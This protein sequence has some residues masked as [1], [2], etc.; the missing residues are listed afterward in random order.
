MRKST[1]RLWIHL[2]FPGFLLAALA[3]CGG[4]GGYGGGGGGN[5][6]QS[7]PP[8]GMSLPGQNL[9][10]APAPAEPFN[11]PS[12]TMTMSSGG[13][14][15]TAIYSETPNNGTTMFDGQEAHSS[16][17][18]LT[19][20]ENGS[21][22]VTEID[23]AY[24]LENPYQ[25]L[26]L[27][28]SSNGKQFDFLYNSTNPLPLTLTVGDS[29]PLGSGTYYVVN[30]NESIGSLT[31]TYSVA[32]NDTSTVELITYATGTVNGQS[33]S[34]TINYAVNASGA[35]ELEWFSILVNGTT[36]TFMNPGYWGY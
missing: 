29:G 32:S 3:A 27:T 31:Q 15:Y 1:P 5:A 12:A 2:V 24:Y 23:T 35:P 22:I 13:N 26:G 20:T 25:P 36:L 7:S 19:I 6:M 11:I 10:S 9:E 18:S 21:P 33:I 14:S 28:L 4:G 34:E 16:T 8:S 17:I 30:T